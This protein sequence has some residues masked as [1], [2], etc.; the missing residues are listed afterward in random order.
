M[1]LTVAA[2]AYCPGVCVRVSER[3]RE[4]VERVGGEIRE[5][6]REEEEKGE[7][8]RKEQQGRKGT[9]QSCCAV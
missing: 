1:D 5:R 8:R 3:G 7:R 6:E 9:I 2:A 4:G